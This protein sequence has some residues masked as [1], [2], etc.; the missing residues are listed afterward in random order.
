MVCPFIADILDVKVRRYVPDLWTVNFPV[1]MSTSPLGFS[2]SHSEYCTGT[3]SLLQPLILLQENTSGSEMFLSW[4]LVLSSWVCSSLIVVST[5]ANTKS[6]IS[7][8]LQLQDPDKVV[9]GAR[10]VVGGFGF[11]FPLPFPPVEGG[12]V[13]PVEGLPPFPPFPPFEGLPPPFPPLDGLLAEERRTRDKTI[14][15][16]KIPDLIVP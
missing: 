8:I 3:V 9:G 16:T 5:S 4:S 2:T 13:V 10:V 11:P 6:L 12:F 14:N 7:S 15:A 1:V